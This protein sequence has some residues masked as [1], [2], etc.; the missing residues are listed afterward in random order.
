[1]PIRRRRFPERMRMENPRHHVVVYRPG[2]EWEGARPGLVLIHGGAWICG[3][4]VLKHWYGRRL[5]RLGYVAVAINYRKMP[6]HPFPA[7]LQDAKAAV[8]WVRAHADSLGI[9]PARV[10]VLGD[11]AGGHLAL[12]LAVTR[13][14][15]GFEHGE[16]DSVSSQVQAAVSLYGPADLS[17]YQHP[18]TY[19]RAG[20]AAA[21]YM[22]RFV[23]QRGPEAFAKA[24][25][26]SYVHEGMCPVLLIHGTRDRLVP[27]E[28]SVAFRD[29]VRECGGEAS[30][31]PVD[32]KGHGFDYIRPTARREVFGR[33][34]DFLEARLRS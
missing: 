8:C 30:L 6:L 20:G 7:C 12:L 10:G 22:R 19:I 9:D 29:R 32:G 13:P 3:A 23:G 25:P 21:F 28:Q 27:F 18:T 31:L 26:I 33:I 24:S 2:P 16:W 17:Y 4:P 11:S 15:D 14:E 1:M 34:A 5:A